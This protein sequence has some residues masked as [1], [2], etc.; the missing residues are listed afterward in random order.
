MGELLGYAGAWLP[1]ED[2]KA[3]MNAVRNLFNEIKSAKSWLERFNI[4]QAFTNNVFRALKSWKHH[5]AAAFL[6]AMLTIAWPPAADF[7]AIW[8]LSSIAALAF[9]FMEQKLQDKSNWR[10]KRLILRACGTTISLVSKIATRINNLL[11]AVKEGIFHGTA[12]V[13]DA[14]FHGYAMAWTKVVKPAAQFVIRKAKNLFAGFLNWALR[15]NQP[16]MAAA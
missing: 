5:L 7:L 3:M 8:G 2:W 12:K 15:R 4:S 9:N 14:V 10:F 16:A 6:L 1:K 11:T 13:V